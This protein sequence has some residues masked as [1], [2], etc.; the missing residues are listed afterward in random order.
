MP[1]TINLV[2]IFERVLD[3]TNFDERHFLQ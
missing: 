1:R 2:R 3:I